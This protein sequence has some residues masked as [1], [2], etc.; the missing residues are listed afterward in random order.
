[1]SLNVAQISVG[2]YDKNF[3]YVIYDEETQNAAIV[4]PSGYL[5]KVMQ[6]VED[7]GLDLTGVLLTHTHHDHFDKLDELLQ[8]YSIPVYLHKAGL[9]KVFSPSAIYPVRDRETLLIGSSQI[10]VLH[11]PGHSEDSIC[12]VIDKNNAADEIPKVIT[13]DTLFVGGCGR[14]G[15]DDVQY[16]YNSL[17]R[18]KGLP[19][20][21]IIYPGHDYGE[22]KNATLAEEKLN[23]KYLVAK[24]FETFKKL[25]LG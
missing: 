13:G 1:M 10:T 18:L 24:D 23:N 21:T 5:E 12:L 6:L 15:K 11:T 19:A 4:D 3:S 25:R 17:I 20:E 8:H 16:L 14:V 9:N 2:G 22:S 7:K